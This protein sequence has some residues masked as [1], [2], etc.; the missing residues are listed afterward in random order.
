MTDLNKK[1]RL[2]FAVCYLACTAVLTFLR[3]DPIALVYFACS[4]APVIFA[5]RLIKNDGIKS[6][7]LTAFFLT[8]VGYQTTF[9]LFYSVHNDY[10]Q[11]LSAV[12]VGIFYTCILM[13][14]DEKKFPWCIGA[15]PV[16]CGL[17]IR[18]AI[19]YCVLLTCVSVA[20][21]KK[22][23][24]VPAIGTAV[25]TAG[26]ILCAVLALTK[27]G[28]F[29]ESRDYLLSR[30]KNP[31]FLL[32][33]AAYLAVKLVKARGISTV[34]LGICLALTVGAAVFATLNLGWTVLALICLCLPVF[35]G[36]K[37]LEND[38]AVRAIKADFARNKLIFAAAIICAL[39]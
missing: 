29:L 16:L 15:V 6:R 28:Y 31:L 10:K 12:G 30:F 5:D 26:F 36:T 19:G 33:I 39:Q 14:T 9:E 17:N 3:H 35:I 38:S 34:K 23:A 2:L 21:L 24:R 1:E 13:L 27:D 4:A 20:S 18:L 8:A 25:G 37:C 11:A 7:T 32:I 22:S